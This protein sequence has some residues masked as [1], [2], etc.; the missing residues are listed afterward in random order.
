MD[1]NKSPGLGCQFHCE[2]GMVEVNR[3]RI[4]AEP[5][6]LAD[7]PDRPDKLTVPENEPHIRNWI[8]CIRSRETANADIGFAQRSSSLCYLVN[9]A[10]EV[11]KV[12]EPLKWNDKKEKFTNCDEGNALLSRPRRPGWELPA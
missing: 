3:D 11:G 5:Q 2:Q 6:S 7:R 9:I 8:E 10:R 12:G 4:W 1:G